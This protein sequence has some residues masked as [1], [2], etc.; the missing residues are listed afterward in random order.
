MNFRAHQQDT[1]P[2]SSSNPLL[3]DCQPITLLH[4]NALQQIVCFDTENGGNVLEPPLEVAI[5]E[6]WRMA[7]CEAKVKLVICEVLGCSVLICTGQAIS[8]FDKLYFI[9]HK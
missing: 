4:P 3:P 8:R 1:C 2:V 7:F 6:P 5:V 9:P